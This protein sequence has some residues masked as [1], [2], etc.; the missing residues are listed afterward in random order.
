MKIIQSKTKEE[1]LKILSN[2][3]PNEDKSVLEKII[4]KLS[5]L[6]LHFVKKYFAKH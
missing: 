1:L 2:E 4:D 5:L 6:S 3:Y